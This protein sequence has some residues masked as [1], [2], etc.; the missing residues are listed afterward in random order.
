MQAL[1]QNKRIKK[2]NIFLLKN[3]RKV[4]IFLPLVLLFLI[5]SYV[6]LMVA[7]ISLSYGIERGQN[8][9]EQILVENSQKELEYY[10]IKEKAS[11]DFSSE[12]VLAKN[13][14]YIDSS[15]Q[16]FVYNK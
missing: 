4:L 13:I 9:L 1:L 7:S 12:L 11:S 2:I 14:D 10:L 16:Q 5:F 3:E 15:L 6:Y 8:D